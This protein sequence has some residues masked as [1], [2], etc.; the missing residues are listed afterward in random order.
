M[1]FSKL[2][3]SNGLQFFTNCSSVGPFHGVQS[4]RN[5]LLQCG[6]PMG[7]QVLPANLLQ[8]GLLFPWGYMSCQK[9]APAR[10]CHWVTAS[11]G[12][13]PALVWGPPQ[14]S[15]GFLLNHG[16]PWAAGGQPASPW[17]LS[18]AAGESLLWRLEPLLQRPWCLQSCFSHIFSLLSSAA[19]AVAEG[20]FPFLKYVITE[21]LPWP[22]VGLSWT[23]LALALFDIG[24]ASGSFPQK[25]PL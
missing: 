24:E 19:V 17:S 6:L 10:A 8:H 23:W 5:R 3:P 7:S 22:A 20:F 13:P 15:G 9:P 12:H 2:S 1:N 14:A 16:P 21:V 11:F 4:F 25:P 18:R